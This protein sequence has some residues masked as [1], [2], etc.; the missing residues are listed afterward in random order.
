MD[1]IEIE[2]FSKEW[3]RLGYFYNARNTDILSNLTPASQLNLDLPPIVSGFDI[4]SV[5]GVQLYEKW[6]TSSVVDIAL[7]VRNFI[8]TTTSVTLVAPKTITYDWTYD[9][10]YPTSQFTFYNSYKSTKALVML[11]SDTVQPLA[12]IP[13]EKNV[14]YTPDPGYYVFH[15]N[16]LVNLIKTEKRYNEVFT[17]P[18]EDLADT[19]RVIPLAT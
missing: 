2:S 16:S 14:A 10:P 4:T 1:K 18:R 5:P 19:F 6:M 11:D 9:S 17:R 13:I 12:T 15:L 7:N 3:G 8:Q